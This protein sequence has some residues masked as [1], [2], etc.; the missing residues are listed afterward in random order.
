MTP[1]NIFAFESNLPRFTSCPQQQ[2]KLISRDRFLCECM[3]LSRA[4]QQ[5]DMII[6]KLYQNSIRLSHLIIIFSHSLSGKGTLSIFHY[7]RPKRLLNVCVIRSHLV[8]QLWSLFFSINNLTI[9][10]P[11]TNR[12]TSQT[13]LFWQ[14]SRSFLLWGH[15][16][17][18]SIKWNFCLFFRFCCASTHFYIDNRKSCVIHVQ[19]LRHFTKHS[20]I[21]TKR[22]LQ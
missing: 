17:R 12:L 15:D 9:L 5:F 7:V 13:I 18:R 21:K 6:R 20:A 1:L 10:L 19:I 8:S 4:W 14:K 3:R 2:Q 11:P 22:K 16:F